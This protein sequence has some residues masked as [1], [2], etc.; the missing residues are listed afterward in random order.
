MSRKDRAKKRRKLQANA[1]DSV[2]GRRAQLAQ[3]AGQHFGGARDLYEVLG[4]PRT[5]GVQDFASAYQRGDLAS[6]IVDAYPDATWREAPE[7]KAEQGFQDA[8]WALEKRVELLSALTRLDR[9]TGLGHYGVLLLGL[10]GGEPMSEEAKG[11]KYELL[12]VQPHGERTAQIIRWDDNPS[13]PR[14]GK[15][16]L[17]RITTGTNWTGMGA[18]QKT[19]TVHHSRVI[20]VAEKP[21]EDASIGTPRL[22]RLWNRLMDMDK[23]IGGSSEVYWQNAAQLMAFVAEK[24]AEWAEGEAE[25]MREQ[26]EEMQHGLRRA[27][28]LRGVTPHSLS[29]STPDARN[30]L[31]SIL[32][33]IAGA[34]GIPKRIL[35]GSERGELSSQQDENNWAARIAERREQYATPQ[36]LNPF[37]QRGQRF[38]FLP[39]GEFE[40][41]WPEADT[42]GEQGRAD[43]ALKK[44]Q[45]LQAYT[46]TPGADLVVPEPEF[47]QWLGEEPQSVYALPDEEPLDESGLGE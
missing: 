4:Y 39:E 36:I 43:I 33:V 10:D 21:L 46:S 44:A 35:L 41:D 29:A 24:D 30:H 6:R 5:L 25:D 17:Y 18:G 45:A 13:S 7:I 34:S 42:L 28:R 23:L 19:L 9:L 27:L 40:V 38:G 1:A 2:L 11:N 47:R 3:R 22:E 31:E 37:I 20:H 16:L 32:E 8:F 15:P 12:Y 26:L 14:Y